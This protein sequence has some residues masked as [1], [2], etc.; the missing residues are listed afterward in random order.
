M[1][2]PGGPH[3]NAILLDWCSARIGTTFQMG[4]VAIGVADGNDLLAVAAFDN[5]RKSASGLPLNIECSFAADSP[6]WAKRGM[7]RGILA[8]PFVQLKVQRV[9]TFIREDNERSIKFT[10]GLGFKQEGFMRD[11]TEG[12]AGVHVTGM[13]REESRRWLG[14]LL[15]G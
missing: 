2:E 13:L 4:S 5:Y 3:L 12:G 1:M 6:R 8:Y 10:Y 15:D 14:D 11:C 7:I 9:T